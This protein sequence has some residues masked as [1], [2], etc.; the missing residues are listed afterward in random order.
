MKYVNVSSFFLNCPS[1]AAMRWKTEMQTNTAFKRTESKATG[2]VLQCQEQPTHK[3]QCST[4]KTRCPLP[5]CCGMLDVARSVASKYD[6]TFPSC[7]LGKWSYTLWS[8]TLVWPCTLLQQRRTA[9][10]PQ[11][12]I[13]DAISVCWPPRRCLQLPT[14]WLWHTDGSKAH[15][16]RTSNLRKKKKGAKKAPSSYVSN[17]SFSVQKLLTVNL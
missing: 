3:E 12:K 4:T 10:N 14:S 6:Y 11:Y 7:S 2:Y 15:H 8:Y 16:Q 5:P 1:L 17:I 9:S 13:Q